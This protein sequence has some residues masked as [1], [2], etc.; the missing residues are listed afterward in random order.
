MELAATSTLDDEYVIIQDTIDTIKR[1]LEN[2]DVGD[3]IKQEIRNTKKSLELE[4]E[5]LLLQVGG[6]DLESEYGTLIVAIE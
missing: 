5:Y 1:Q 3:R 6:A 2:P 4:A